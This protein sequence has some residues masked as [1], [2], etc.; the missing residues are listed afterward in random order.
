MPYHQIH[1]LD[2]S[3]VLSL[4]RVSHRNRFR[5][6]DLAGRFI[7]PA[8]PGQRLHKQRKKERWFFCRA[9]QRLTRKMY[10]F[11]NSLFRLSRNNQCDETG[12]NCFGLGTIFSNY[13]HVEDHPS[14]LSYS[15]FINFVLHPLSPLEMCL[16]ICINI[17]PRAFKP[18]YTTLFRSSHRSLLRWIPSV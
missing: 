10:I 5:I 3:L 11:H 12:W 13:F 18:K 15:C 1:S 7:R 2:F 9:L 6:E 17:V 8:R 16:K 14:F 4:C